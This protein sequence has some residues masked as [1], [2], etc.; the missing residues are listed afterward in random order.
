MRRVSDLIGSFLGRPP[1]AHWAAPFPFGRADQIEVME[2]VLARCRDYRSANI[3]LTL[4]PDDDMYAR[5]DPNAMERYLSVG[6]SA[7]ELISEAMLLARR[8]EFARVL[9]LPCGCGRVTRHLVQ[10]FR[11]SQIFVSDIERNKQAFVTSQF[12]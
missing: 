4:S 6:V 11:D 12:G 8:A 2:S 10:F 5:A 3:D 1:V 7:I 9:D